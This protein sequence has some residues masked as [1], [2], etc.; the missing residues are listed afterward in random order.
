MKWILA[1]SNVQNQKERAKPIK[2]GHLDIV[3]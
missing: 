2:A 3:H 1:V